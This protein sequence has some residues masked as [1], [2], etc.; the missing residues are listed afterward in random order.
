MLNG[1]PGDRRDSTNPMARKRR[2]S[3]WQA[4]ADYFPTSCTMILRSLPTNR[5]GTPSS[6]IF[7]ARRGRNGRN[8][9]TRNILQGTSLFS[10]F[11]SATLSV[12]SRKQG[13]CAQNTGGGMAPQ[14]STTQVPSPLAPSLQSLNALPA[15]ACNNLRR[16]PAH[17]RRRPAPPSSFRRPSCAKR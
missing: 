3:G 16:Q 13:F 6:R 1:P 10:I 5:P 4:L 15:A 17:W 11:C 7:S 8:S 9:F 14:N 12:T 2:P